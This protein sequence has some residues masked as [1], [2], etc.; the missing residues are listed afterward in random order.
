MA[1]Q[2]YLSRVAGVAPAPQLT[3]VTDSTTAQPATLSSLLQHLSSPAGAPRP[4][5]PVSTQPAME[6][7][8]SGLDGHRTARANPHPRKDPGPVARPAPALAPSV[9]EPARPS[10][11]ESPAA[12]R[13]LIIANVPAALKTALTPGPRRSA[14]A[15]AQA[16]RPAMAD[17]APTDVA[18]PASVRVHIGTVEVRTKAPPVNAVPPA[19]AQVPAPPAFPAPPRGYG[20]GYGLSQR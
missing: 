13:P 6:A 2:S 18:Q 9:D 7:P 15:A 16:V 10:P 17:R 11:I 14:S 1:R 12:D 19:P 20:W 8:V 4:L 5:M 3:A